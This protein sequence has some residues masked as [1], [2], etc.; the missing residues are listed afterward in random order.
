[1]KLHLAFPVLSFVMA[2]FSPLLIVAA[3]PAPTAAGYWAGSISLPNQ[4]LAIAVELTRASGSAWEGTI[5][6]PMQGVRGFKLDA[7]K[8]ADTAVGF[9]L[10]GVP[11][12]P[13]FSGK[14]AVDARSIAGLFAQGEV[15]VPFRLERAVRPAPKLEEVTPAHGVP[16]EGVVGKWRGHISPMPNVEL[17]LGL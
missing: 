14:L 5:D 16:G 17:R 8:I 1:M 4:E 11:G 12:N 15:Q 13:S 3:E 2:L 10:T 6:I 7:I 9:V